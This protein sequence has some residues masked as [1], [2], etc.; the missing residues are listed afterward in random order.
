MSTSE[1]PF[2]LLTRTH[3][4]IVDP[5]AGALVIMAAASVVTAIVTGAITTVLAPLVE[6]RQM[7]VGGRTT[8]RLLVVAGQAAFFTCEVVIDPPRVSGM[9]GVVGG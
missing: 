6:M 1:Q 5:H 2:A 8:L 4:Q 3:A 7:F 9:L